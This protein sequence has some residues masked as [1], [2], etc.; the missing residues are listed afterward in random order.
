M[1]SFENIFD[2]TDFGAAAD[3]KTDC[4]FAVQKAVD[5]AE[6]VQG[7]IYVPSGIYLCGTIKL[8][9]FVTIEGEA[10]WTYRKNGGS[11]L[12]LVN[13]NAECLIDVTD[14]YGAAIKGL[15]VQGNKLGENIHGIALLR[16]ENAKHR[17]EDAFLIENCRISDFS[18][19]G[20]H[21]ERV[22]CYT[23]R[24]SQLCFNRGNGLY[25]KGWDAFISDNWFSHNEGAG[26]LSDE[27]MS[28]VMF[29]GNRVEENYVAG[30]KLI[31]PICVTITG[32]AFD[33]NGGAGLDMKNPLGARAINVSVVGNNF[34]R[35]GIPLTRASSTSTNSFAS[36]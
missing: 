25:M 4:T 3:G 1:P 27:V 35:N 20:V 11:I 9:P 36:P 12:S 19:D 22:W 10:R 31:N 29:T 6:K 8:K 17:E 7:K 2:I 15:C 21:F 5:A 32:N 30:L 33:S 24:H 34:H 23:V 28:A 16:S 26:V 13:G 14:A 18:G